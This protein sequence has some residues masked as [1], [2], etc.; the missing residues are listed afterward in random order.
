MFGH[1]VDLDGNLS[2]VLSR[3]EGRNH[4]ALKFAYPA[5]PIPLTLSLCCFRVDR[6][7][8]GSAN[9]LFS[10]TQQCTREVSH[11]SPCYPWPFANYG[12]SSVAGPQVM[13]VDTPRA[14]SIVRRLLYLLRCRSGRQQKQFK[15]QRTF[16]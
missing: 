7:S 16:V 12:S 4:Q 6:A 5:P 15:L 10:L 11:C 3:P 8:V 2:L 9:V 13:V 14:S 1:L